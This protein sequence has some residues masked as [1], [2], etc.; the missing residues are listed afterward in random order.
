MKIIAVPAIVAAALAVSQAAPAGAAAEEPKAAPPAR[1]AC[2]LEIEFGSYAMGIDRKTLELVELILAR[3]AAVTSV[4]RRAWGREG[5]VTLCATIPRAGYRERLFE[6]IASIFPARPRGPLSITAD[7]G[8]VFR[9][10]N[11]TPLRQRRPRRG[12]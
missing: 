1:A 7:N 6:T 8:R 9:A 11:D 2:S 10:N 12:R 4:T 3:E 5:E